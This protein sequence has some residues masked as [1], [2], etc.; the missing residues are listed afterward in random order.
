MYGANQTL[1]IIPTVP[2]GEDPEGRPL[3]DDGD[4]FTVRG[5]LWEATSREL[6]D[7]V[8]TTVRELKARVPADTAVTHRD[9]IADEDGNVYRIITVTKRRG[10]SGRIEHISLKLARTG[11]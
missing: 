4:R 11:A 10:L 8:Y 1:T 7:G 5:N 6:V 3:T 9:R 2:A